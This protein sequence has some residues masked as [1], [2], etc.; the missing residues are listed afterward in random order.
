MKKVVFILNAI[1]CICIVS[2]HRSPKPLQ[3]EE[4]IK[5][6]AESPNINVS[7]KQYVV[8]APT[9]WRETDTSIQGVKVYFIFAPKDG[10]NIQSN[11]NIVNGNMQGYS[12]D[13]Y[14]K[15]TLSNMQQSLPS[16]KELGQGDFETDSHVKAK[17]I[18]YSE[19]MNGIDFEHIVYTIPIN[20]I[21]YG[22]TGTSAQGKL[23]KY[24][25]DFDAIAKS[26]HLK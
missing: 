19:S 25:S 22:L 14:V 15:A 4:I 24:K 12:L 1:I 9:G 17:W 11:L 6:A 7:H 18:H 26:F 2:C 5:Q 21:A 20:G 13:D 8:N 10:S 16:F 23:D 3:S